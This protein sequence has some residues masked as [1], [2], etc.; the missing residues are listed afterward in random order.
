[1]VRHI[2]AGRYAEACAAYKLYRFSGGY[3]CSVPGNRVCAGVWSR[4]LQRSAKCESA[5]GETSPQTR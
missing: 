3:D 2:N 5:N 4:N 1:M